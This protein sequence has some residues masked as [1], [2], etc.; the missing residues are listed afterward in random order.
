MTAGFDRKSLVILGVFAVL[1]AGA[2]VSWREYLSFSLADFDPLLAGCWVGMVGLMIYRVDARRDGV[3]A[4]VALAGGALI[5][6][7][8]TRSGLWVYI[9]G[10]QPPLFILPAWPA[11]ALATD[12]VAWALD[13]RAPS[14]GPWPLLYGISILVFAA[15][16]ARWT[17]PGW[18]HPLTWLAWGCVALTAATGVREGRRSDLVRFAAGCLVGY[19]LE[20]WGTSRGCW[21]YWSGEVPPVI[22]VLSHGFA[23]VAFAR[24][25]ALAEALWRRT[26]PPRENP[27]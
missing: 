8:G 11:A 18:G 12:R 20:Y 6:T 13:R 5:E 2:A 15:W 1:G 10:E 22:A 25:A 3:L 26:M 24:G 21:V 14:R 19:P 17:R 16:L 4:A 9:T 7:W 27:T 23:T